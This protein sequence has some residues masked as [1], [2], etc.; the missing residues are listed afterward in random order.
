M[1]YIKQEIS[2]ILDSGTDAGAVNKSAD[3]SYFEIQLQD[4]LALPNDAINVQLAVEE[5]EIWWTVPNVIT[6][7]ND[8]FYVTHAGVPYIVTIPQGLYDLTGISQTI[9]RELENL[10]L[11]TSPALFTFSPDTATSKVEIKF[12]Y[13]TTSIDFTQPDTPRLLLGFNAAVIGL[14][15][16]AGETIVADNVAS[17]NTVNYFLLHSD[18]TSSGIR[19]NNTYTQTVAKVAIDVAPGSQIV[20]KPFNPARIN[21]DDLIGASRTNIKVW[22]TDD[23]NNRVNTNTESYS[24]RVV[25]RY[26][27]PV[28]KVLYGQ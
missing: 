25:I 22:L 15:P 9:L 18:L 21:A 26:Q 4:P 17:F 5:A 23:L 28:E 1:S 2:M 7:Q 3:G 14:V 20:Y 11:P 10:G 24:L 12:N 16:V 13:T 27:V 6:G 8:K 19:N